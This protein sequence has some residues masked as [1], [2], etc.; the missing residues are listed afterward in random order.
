MFREGTYSRFKLRIYIRAFKHYRQRLTRGWDDRE[1]WNLDVTMAEFIY[2]RLKRLK[3]IQH[4]YPADLNEEEWS[5]I[6]DKMI[7]AFKLIKEE[8]Y[9]IKKDPGE[10]TEGLNLFVEYYSNLWD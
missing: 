10:I 7:L 2:P 6:L 5:E 8:D 1:L 3:E 9:Y 4:G